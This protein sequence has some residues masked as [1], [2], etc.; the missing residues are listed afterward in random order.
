ME[1]TIEGDKYFDFFGRKLRMLMKIRVLSE[2]AFHFKTAA[3]EL[4]VQ[5]AVHGY[6]VYKDIWSQTVG[7]EFNCRQQPDKTED[8]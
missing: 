4:T 3:F 6:H 5:T 1:K 7:N 8:S 2:R